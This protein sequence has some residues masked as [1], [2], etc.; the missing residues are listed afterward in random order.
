MQTI[1]KFSIITLSVLLVLSIQGKSWGATDA[2]KI[3]IDA[4]H[5][6]ANIESGHS[7]YTG[8][9]KVRQGELILTGDQI[10]VIQKNNEVEKITVIGKPAHYN[11]VTDKGEVI[12]ADS[13]RM[14]YAASKNLLILT[15]NA[16][17]NHPEHHISSQKIIYNTLTKVA[18]AGDPNSA[19]KPDSSERVKIT[20]TPKN[21]DGDTDETDEKP[22]G[23]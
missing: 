10:T 17:L 1:N 23:K 5:M 18:V 7:T 9:V 15:I 16:N 19:D 8:N 21:Q 20:L 4:D 3:H 2:E 14:V 6:K 11:H 22:T 13:E 12:E